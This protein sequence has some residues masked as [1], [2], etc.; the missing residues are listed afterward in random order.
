MRAGIRKYSY[1]ILLALSFLLVAA[2]W[3]VRYEFPGNKEELAGIVPVTESFIPPMQGETETK[4][5]TESAPE[6]VMYRADSSWFDDALFIGD[7]RTVGL[8][9][10]GDLGKAEVLADSG[11]SVYKLFGKKFELSSGE[12]GTLEELLSQRTFGKIYLMLGINELGYDH[13]RT[14]AKYQDAVERIQK[15]QPHAMIFLQA[16]LHIAKEKSESSPIYNNENIDRFNRAVEKLAKDKGYFY[17]DVNEL[18]D[19]AEGNLSDEYTVD[20][21]HVL[22]KY[23]SDWVDWILEHAIRYEKTSPT[24]DESPG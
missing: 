7:S 15:L 5:E 2:A 20:Q 21:A 13:D 3:G 19:D 23:Y 10:Y 12:K 22:G 1:T 14:V 11:M 18:F 4:E 16:N 24:G 8:H 9:E 6:P 17:L